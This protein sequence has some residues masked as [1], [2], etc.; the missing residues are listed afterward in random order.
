V[1]SFPEL[2]SFLKGRFAARP[3]R[4]VIHCELPGMGVVKAHMPN[5]G[6]MGELLLPQVT[7]YL[8]R[9]DNPSRKLA[10]TAVAVERNGTPVFLHT[11][12][13]NRV[14]QH[15]LETGRVPGLRHVKIVKAEAKH[16]NSRFDFLIEQRNRQRYVEVKSVTLF[17]NGIAMFPD[18]PTERGRKHL[19]ELADLSE[20]GNKSVVLFLIHSLGCDYFVPD[21]HTDL[22]FSKTLYELRERL[23]IIPLS[24]GWTPSLRL[25]DEA[26]VLPIPWRHV[27]RHFVDRGLIIHVLHHARSS[28]I[29]LERV[30]TDLDRSV[31]ASTASVLK[32]LSVSSSK[33]V[34]EVV[35]H[36]RHPV[37]TPDDLYGFASESLDAL[38]TSVHAIKYFNLYTSRDK[39]EQH[40]GFQALLEELRLRKL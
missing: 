11:H 16:G 6:R 21:I 15:L 24:V 5:P 27:T 40:S 25:R 4:F 30:D 10:Y 20:P 35:K 37:R 9:S 26:K 2:K 32:R 12:L 38:Y 17:G 18:A 33:P 1:T 36:V 19:T 14:A 29:V 13:N 7:L 28:S 22:R 34:A 31:R 3:N 8:T 39:P 23:S